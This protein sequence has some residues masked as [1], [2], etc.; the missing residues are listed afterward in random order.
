MLSIPI[1]GMNDDPLNAMNQF[2]RTV[3]TILQWLRGLAPAAVENGVGGGHA[4]GRCRIIASHDAD[5]NTD[6]GSSVAA[7]KRA[8]F[9]KSLCPA[10]LGFSIGRSGTPFG[11]SID[12]TGGG[13]LPSKAKDNCRKV[14]LRVIAFRTG[15]ELNDVGTHEKSSDIAMTTRPT[16]AN[17][18][19]QAVTGISPKKRAA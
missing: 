10:H 1:L 4:G 19:R 2:E 17:E 13:V 9:D 6:C 11:R 16:S 7:C 3:A 14:R 8:N 12:R 18:V 15:D 5:E